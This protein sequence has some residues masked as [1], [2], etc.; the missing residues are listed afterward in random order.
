MLDKTEMVVVASAI[1]LI[2]LVLWYFFGMR[3]E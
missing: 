1:A 2:V 3:R